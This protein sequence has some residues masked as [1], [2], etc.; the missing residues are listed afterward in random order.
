[1]PFENK[2]NLS[3]T[4]IESEGSQVFLSIHQQNLDYR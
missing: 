1:M 4:L 3:F 2:Q